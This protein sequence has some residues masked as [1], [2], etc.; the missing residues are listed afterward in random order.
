MDNEILVADEVAKILRI[1]R[2]RVYELVRTGKI[3]AIRLGDRQIRFS[4]DSI[5]R[6]LESG[7]TKSGGPNYEA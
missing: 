4:A 5:R 2:Q 3:P 1:D 6:W 7:G